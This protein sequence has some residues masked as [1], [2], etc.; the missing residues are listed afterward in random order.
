MR[1]A[2]AGLLAA[3]INKG[4]SASTARLAF[5]IG[6]A[7]AALIYNGSAPRITVRSR[8]TNDKT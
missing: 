4:D 7:T 3:R 8:H 5:E 6:C 1:S 2:P